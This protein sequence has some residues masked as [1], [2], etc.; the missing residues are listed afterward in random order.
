MSISGKDG[1]ADRDALKQQLE[2]E[3]EEDQPADESAEML[4]T[5]WCT[6]SVFGCRE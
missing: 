1:Q 2:T 6:S 4:M 5:W 3:Y